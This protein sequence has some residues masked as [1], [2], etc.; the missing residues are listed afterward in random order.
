MTITFITSILSK[1]IK[2]TR[3]ANLIITAFIEK[4]KYFLLQKKNEEYLMLFLHYYLSLYTT[5]YLH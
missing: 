1:K 5:A 2:S 4:L 3:F